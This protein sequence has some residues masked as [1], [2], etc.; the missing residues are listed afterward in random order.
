M[1]SSDITLLYHGAV[2]KPMPVTYNEMIRARHEYENQLVTLH[3]VV[4]SADLALSLKAPVLSA[5]MIMLMDGGDIEVHVDSSDENALKGLLDAEVEVTGTVE[6]KFDG[7]YQLTGLGLNVSSLANIKI[8][9]RA[10]TSPWSLPVT[11][12]NEILSGYHVQNLSQRMRV[13]GVITYYQPGSAVVLENGN[14]SLWIAT[15]TSA[16][17]HI[18]DQA[19]AT[20]FPSLS[21]GFLT[22]TEGEIRDNRI[23]A[24]IAPLPVTWQQL[25]YSRHFFDLVSIQGQVVMEIRERAQDE[26]VLSSQGQMFSAIYRHPEVGGVLLPPMKQIPVGSRVNVSGI[27]FLS[28]RI[29]S[30]PTTKRRSIFCCALPKTLRS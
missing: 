25:V 1:Q 24:P 21:N 8:L 29:T 28:L 23:P 26:Y 12:M 14:K 6:P 19:D 20:G 5:R 17:L 3:A 18:G 16:P 4:R 15:R 10:K 13:H 9:H 7:K 30:L 11:P 27:C 2:P 22:L